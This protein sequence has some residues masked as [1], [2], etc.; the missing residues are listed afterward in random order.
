M[1]SS[2]KFTILFILSVFGCQLF[3]LHAQTPGCE[4]GQYLF[5]TPDAYN[6]P[7]R[8]P[9]ITTTRCGDVI[10]VVDRRYC[11]ADIGYGR[12]DIVARTSHDNGVTW[13]ADTVIQRG[14]GVAGAADCGYG[15]AA[16]V[17]DRTSDRVLC[18]SVTGNVAYINGTRENPNRVARWYGEKGGRCWTKAEDVTDDFYDML[19]FTRTMFIG[20]GRLMQSRIVKLGKYYR[21]YCSVLTRTIKP[22]GA[23]VACN[24]VIYTDDFGQS[25]AVLGG[26]TLDGNDSPC[27]GGDEP[28]VEE[29]PNGDV[30]LSSRK[31]RGR[32]F[33][34]FHFDNLRNNAT[35]GRWD[36][37][38]ASHD[39]REGITVGNNSTNGEIYLVDAVETKS[40]RAVKL[41]LQSLP[42]GEGRERV[43]FWYKEIVPN[44]WYSSLA[45]AHK[46]TRGMEVTQK[47]SAYSTMTLQADG[48][49]GFF[50]EEE[51]QWY[52]MV[53]VPL[54]ISQITNGEYK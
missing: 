15:D 19:P 49:I 37:C 17:A 14:S 28:K 50:Y 34:V 53:Y 25:W 38:V 30:V 7:Y 22:D 3:A 4:G 26:T 12:I 18:M 10:A 5:V 27:I 40:G 1:K 6:V 13:G 2:L 33:N 44:G 20:S 32:Y 54:T 45:F 52:S 42:F 36:K 24:Y 16:I 46:W 47:G 35:V 39:V 23:D 11:G 51:P 41:M 9:A 48:R 8:I 29:L 21:V 31:H 43:G